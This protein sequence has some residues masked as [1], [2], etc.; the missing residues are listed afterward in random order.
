[1]GKISASIKRSFLLHLKNK[2]VDL[3][4]IREGKRMAQESFQELDSLKDKALEGER[5]PL[6]MLYTAAITMMSNCVYPLM[7]TKEMKE[8]KK[9]T[10]SQ[11]DLYHPSYPPMSPVTDSYYIQNEMLDLQVGQ[12]KETLSGIFL[13]L[14]EI[15]NIP[16]EEVTA[17][18][19]LHNSKMSIYK[20]CK[21]SGDKILLKE[22][23]TDEEHWAVCP[24]GYKG[25]VGQLW[26]VRLMPGFPQYCDYSLVNMTPYILLTYSENDWL[27]FFERNN[28]NKDNFH[29]FMKFGPKKNYW[30]EFVFWGYC[31]YTKEAIFVSGLPDKKESLPCGDN[32]TE[33]NLLSESFNTQLLQADKKQ[34]LSHQPAYRG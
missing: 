1:M 2:V 7:G 33:S 23:L 18:K 27:K 12:D 20:L 30:N 28:V 32:F 14:V 9:V 21:K 24:A 34:I 31:N 29:N 26:Y 3:E 17:I 19:N 15:L 11:E 10:M 22:I 8:F 16:L 4:G 6:H 13:D 25:K 5:D